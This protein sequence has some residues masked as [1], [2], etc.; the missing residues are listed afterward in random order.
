MLDHVRD[1]KAEPGTA[2]PNLGFNLLIN[3]L[4]QSTL[5]LARFINERKRCRI[6]III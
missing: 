2:N 6:A 1:E 5:R 4:K 3:L